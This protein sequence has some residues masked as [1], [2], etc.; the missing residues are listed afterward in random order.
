M[1]KCL[2]VILTCVLCACLVSLPIAAFSEAVDGMVFPATVQA[3][4]EVAVKAPA[5]GELENFTVRAGDAVNAGDTLFT[6]EP[7]RVFADIDGVVADVYVKPGAIA[8]AAVARYG[9]A[10]R[11]EHADRY[12]IQANVRTGYN[13]V[14]NRDLYVG[15]PVYLRSANEKHFADGVITAAG[16][17][18]FTVQVLGGDL[19]YTQDVKI[20]REPDYDSKTLLARASL[21]TVAPYEVSASGTVTEVAVQRGD[22][23]QAGDFLFAYV[24]DALEPELRGTASPTAAKADSGLII[25]AV[26]VQQGASVQKGQALATAYIA[27]EYQLV[28]QAEEGEAGAIHPGDVMTVR[29]EE[30]DVPVMEATVTAVSPLGT[31]GEISKYTVYLDFEAPEGV[32]I[33]MHAMVEK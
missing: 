16:G 15:T 27:G 28:A 3:K 25:S 23:V 5:S 8:D 17:G 30:L 2:T 11:I 29:F 9:A 22:K 21:S 12:E 10:L 31:D 26:N 20:Y 6:V 1:R 13:T 24:P 19:V 33:G 18:S 4:R 7:K 14:E 32:W